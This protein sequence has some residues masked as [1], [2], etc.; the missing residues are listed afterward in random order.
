MSHPSQLLSPS[1]KDFLRA[2]NKGDYQRVGDLLEKDRLLGTTEILGH[3]L[4]EASRGGHADTIKTLLLQPGVNVNFEADGG[5]TA[6]MV[7]ARYGHTAAVYELLKGG[8]TAGADPAKVDTVGNTAFIYACGGE[9]VMGKELHLK[10][11]RAAQRTKIVKAL[12]ESD[13]AINADGSLRFDPGKRNNNGH[14]GFRFAVDSGSFAIVNFLLGWSRGGARRGNPLQVNS[15]DHMKMTPFHV[16][17]QKCDFN[18]VQL[19]FRHAGLLPGD[20]D[21]NDDGEDCR[22]ESGLHLACRLLVNSPKEGR[23]AVLPIVDL[24]GQRHP[25][26]E[27]QRYLNRTDRISRKVPLRILVDAGDLEGIHTLLKYGRVALMKEEV[28]QEITEKTLSKEGKEQL[29]AEVQKFNEARAKYFRKS[30]RIVGPRLGSGAFGEVYEGVYTDEDGVDQKLA[31]KVA[32]LDLGTA[33]RDV[34][35]REFWNELSHWALLDYE[36]CPYILP[37]LGYGEPEITEY[38]PYS[39]GFGL[40]SPLGNGGS[41]V[42]ALWDSQRTHLQSPKV[43]A[44][45]AVRLMLEIA[46]GLEFLHSRN[47]VHGDFKPGQVILFKDKS[48]TLTAKIGDFGMARLTG[49]VTLYSSRLQNALKEGKPTHGTLAFHSPEMVHNAVIKKTREQDVWAFGMTLFMAFNGGNEP[50]RDRYYTQE[51]VGRSH[52]LSDRWYH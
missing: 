3:G 27:L 40:L 23:G 29:D 6:L 15:Q 28:L 31:V 25:N 43:H 22:G 33:A 47:M 12:L 18:M 35:Y 2:C 8:A 17:V 24:L 39:R 14:N 4:K 7:A 34:Q 42:Y 13:Y 9:R 45:F 50:W 41:L 26:S 16:A 37:L 11:P 51:E 1:E 21:V 38:W 52:T 46:T 49:A 32:R 5:R 30:F 19:L 20:I 48:G 36:K 10:A 44:K